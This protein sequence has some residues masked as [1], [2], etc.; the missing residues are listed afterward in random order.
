MPRHDRCLPGLARGARAPGCTSPGRMEPNAGRVPLSPRGKGVGPTP[1]VKR[2][3]R[4]G[5]AGPRV[6]AYRVHPAHH[7]ARQHAEP[8]QEPWA[9]SAS[10][11][12]SGWM[13]ASDLCSQV[14]LRLRPWQRRSPSAPAAPAGARQSSPCWIRRSQV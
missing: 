7:F 9:T 5:K 1:G 3:D 8:N 14:G 6:P 12:K 13:V 2:Q 11:T 4:F 10:L